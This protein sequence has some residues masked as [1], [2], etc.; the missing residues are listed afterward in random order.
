[1]A[2]YEV[3]FVRRETIFTRYYM[4]VEADSSEAAMRKVES[5]NTTPE[6]ESTLE[7]GKCLGMGEDCHIVEVE[8]AHELKEKEDA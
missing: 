2:K 1:M 4:T 6:E 8:W 3:A 7:E 5:F